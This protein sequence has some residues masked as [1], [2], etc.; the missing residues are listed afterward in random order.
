MNC[1]R[2][3]VTAAAAVSLFGASAIA[4]EIY[5]YTDADGNVHYGDRPS[6]ADTEQ[7]VAI[8]SRR[9]TPAAAPSED[10]EPEATVAVAPAE[11]DA[12]E[13]AAKKKTRS[14]KIA[15]QKARD[16]RCASARAKLETLVTSR[17]LY[18]ETEDGERQ[19]LNDA[20]I[21]EAR[22]RAQEL[23]QQHCS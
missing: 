6:G 14:E 9:S 10:A 16:K 4:G 3:L 22:A 8:A 13:A 19:Y 21:D 17:R 2:I 11:T 5:R 15:E 1:K 12:Q 7:R 23:V 20:E 18:R